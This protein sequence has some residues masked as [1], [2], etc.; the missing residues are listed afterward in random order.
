M[1]SHDN[2]PPL[3]A[4]A[5]INPFSLVLTNSG[6]LWGGGIV[7]DLVGVFWESKASVVLDMLLLRI[8]WN[9]SLEVVQWVG[10][11]LLNWS[12]FHIQIMLTAV[13]LYGFFSFV[14]KTEVLSA[15]FEFCLPRSCLDMYGPV[16][17]PIWF[18]CDL[19]CKIQDIAEPRTGNYR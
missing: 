10:S 1:W 11:K 17:G 4:C 19:S 3:H 2:I 12:K 16:L 9:E 14:P 5:L 7:I 8:V 13:C 18:S 6:R 15:Y